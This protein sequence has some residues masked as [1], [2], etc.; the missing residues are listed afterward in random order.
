MPPARPIKTATLFLWAFFLW[1][2]SLAC[3]QTVSLADGSTGVASRL[4]GFSHL[5]ENGGFSVAA[6]DRILASQNEDRSFIP[7]STVKIATA[8]LALETLGPDFRFKTEFYLRGQRTLLIKGYGD[9]FLVSETIPPIALAL[10]R[11]GVSTIDGLILDQTYFTAAPLADG[12]EN[13]A[14]PYDAP[15]T[16]LAV[17]FN[18]LPLLKHDTGRVESAEPQTPLLPIM[19]EI[20]AQL[21]PGKHRV[22]VNGFPASGTALNPDRYAAELFISL[23]NSAGIDTASDFTRGTREQTDRLIYRH[24]SDKTLRE[25]IRSSLEFSSNFMANQLF[26]ASGAKMFGPPAT[27]QKARQAMAELLLEYCAIEPSRMRLVEGSGLSRAN[28]ATPEAMLQLLR[29]FRPH[30]NLLGERDGI[31]LKSG[32]LQDVHNYVGYFPTPA[33]LDPFVIFLNQPENTRHE[34]LELLRRLHRD[35]EPGGKRNHLP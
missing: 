31:L 29:V 9:P 24:F 16:P 13:S 26:L 19:H 8:L 10:M 3:S 4:Q 30:A 25:L 33:G 20:G 35:S 23:F 32:S 17:N 2:F 7:A 27:W 15:N 6:G 34:V 12:S 5:V 1:T 21:S 22:N 11:N 14:N 18:A 28:R